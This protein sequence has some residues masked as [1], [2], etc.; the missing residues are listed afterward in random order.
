MW[1]RF[2]TPLPSRLNSCLFHVRSHSV[3]LGIT[4][5]LSSSLVLLPQPVLS[6]Q[7]GPCSNIHAGCDYVPPYMGK[8]IAGTQALQAAQRGLQT[9]RNSLGALLTYVPFSSP[10]HQGQAQEENSSGTG[11]AGSRREVMLYPS[12]VGCW[13]WVCNGLFF[14]RGRL[15]GVGSAQL[16]VGDTS[17]P[18]PGALC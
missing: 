1:R 18:S 14:R 3:P 2:N 8:G 16:A 9:L 12:P 17:S 15:V 7:Q 5:Q 6:T 4:A 10:L 11:S 13:V